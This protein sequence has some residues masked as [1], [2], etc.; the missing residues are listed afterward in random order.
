MT[1]GQLHHQSHHRTN[2]KLDSSIDREASQ[3]RLDEI[4]KDPQLIHSG[5]GLL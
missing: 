5:L 1:E 4:R 2:W 3:L